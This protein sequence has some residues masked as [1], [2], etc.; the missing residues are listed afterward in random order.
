MVGIGAYTLFN[1]EWLESRVEKLMFIL[2]SAFVQSPICHRRLSIDSPS[3]VHRLS[4]E[5]MEK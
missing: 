2:R 3:I 4:I 5:T 1:A